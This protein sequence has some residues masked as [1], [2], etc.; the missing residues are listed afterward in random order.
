MNESY[1]DYTDQL[2]DRARVFAKPEA[3]EG[4]R[5]VEVATLIMGPSNANYLAEF[6]AEVIKV[7]LPGVGDTMRYVITDGRPWRNAN[8]AFF[9]QNRSKYHVGLDIRTPEGQELLRALAAKSDFLVENLR[10]GTMEEWGLGWRQLSALNPRLIYMADSGF[11]QWGPFS[12]GRASYDGVA[13]V[14]SGL[15]EITGFPGRPPTKVGVW[16]GD[17]LG[18]LLAAIAGLAALEHREATGRGQFIDLAQTEGLIRV[19][20]WTWLYHH[21][22]GRDRP[23]AGNRDLAISPSGI[24]RVKDGFCAIAAGLD[25]EFRGLCHAMGRPELAADPRFKTLQARLDPN[26]NEELSRLISEWVAG[27]TQAE[28]DHSGVQ[29]GFASAPVMNAEA[30]YHDEHY[31]RRGTVWAFEDPLYGEIVDHGPVPKLSE[32]PGRIKWA[33]KPVGWHNEY[34]LRTILG[35]T[36]AEIQ[37]LEEKKVI[38]QWGPRPGAK[39]PDDWQ[40]EGRVFQ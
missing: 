15:A 18:A 2:F 24:F 39:P 17:Y 27:Q 5:V 9:P 10:A 30:I 20:D 33:A 1:F 36:S 23:R 34:V 38:G 4:L 6:G 25:E 26:H 14:V 16:L 32:T 22:T 7:E 3:L 37:E 8:P 35:L 12:Q 11:G 31:R 28:L 29:H 19:M 40:G 13:Q 21:L